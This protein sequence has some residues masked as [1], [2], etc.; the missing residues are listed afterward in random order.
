MVEHDEGAS[1]REF[2]QTLGVGAA[3]MLIGGGMPSMA[4]QPVNPCEPPAHGA[5]TPFRRDC[6]PIRPRQVANRL[7]AAEIT[8]LKAAYQAMRDLDT[9]DP[10]DPRGFTQQKNVHCYWCVTNDPSIQVHGSWKFF[11]WHRA[12]LYF[13]ERILG[14]LIGNEN[15]RLPFWGWDIPGFT[16]LPNP[17]ITPNDATNPLFNPTRHLAAGTPL[18]DEDVGASVI[19][20]VLGLAN[21][22]EF[23][24]A[25]TFSGVPEGS[26]HGTVHVDVGGDMGAFGTAARDPIFYQHHATV[27]KLW[28]DWNKGSSTHTDPSDAAFQNLTFTFFDENKVWRSITA[29]QILDHE[30]SL[31]YVYEPYRFWDV[32][33]CFIWRPIKINWPATQKIVIP[34]RSIL[35]EALAGGRLVRIHFSQLQ[36]PRDRSTVYRIYASQAEAQ[37]D[38]GPSSPGYLGNV[39]VVLND[40]ENQHPIRGVVNVVATLNR[41]VRAALV[42]GEALTPFLVD[43][44]EKAGNKRVVP[45][46]AADVFFT[47]GEVDH[48]Q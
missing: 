26:P 43:R 7:T 3:G 46:R 13:H 2:L 29:A 35:A 32:F 41:S 45:V 31:R 37:A 19:S 14:K 16:R 22:S 12:Y 25:A 40:P 47:V 20:S 6:R 39:G 27:D 11:A 34:P 21:F 23:G 4:Y 33:P 30:R 10:N 38:K 17:Y 28:S 36:V 8:Q 48:E 18:P 44:N 5:A 1:R 42:R 15:F 24:G 9:S